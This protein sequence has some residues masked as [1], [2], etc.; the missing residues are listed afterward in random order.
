MKQL[1]IDEHTPAD[2]MML[3]RSYSAII[4]T[5]IR[6]YQRAPADVAKADLDRYKQ[7]GET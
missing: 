3:F 2:T 1:G 6:N 7:L 5:E 4:Y